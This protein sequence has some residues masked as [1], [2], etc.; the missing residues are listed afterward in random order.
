MI[1]LGVCVAS[2]ITDIDHIVEAERLGYSHAW[3]ADSHMIWSDP[4]AVLALAADRTSSIRLGTGVAVAG[5]RPAPVAAASIA[6][7]NAL[8]PGRT[9]FGVGTGNTA[10]RIMGHKPM[11][12]DEFDRYLESIRPLLRGDRVDFDW[13]GKIS[14]IRH[15]MPTSG[16]VA[17]EPKIPMYVSGF[18][19]RSLGLAGKH[20]DGAVL[21]IPPD[22][23][24]MERVW[25]SIEAGAAETGR[26]ID[27]STF[28]TSSLTTAVVLQPGEA[29]DSARVKEQC[30]AFA[31]A[32][33]HY[34][35]DQWR[36]FGRRPSGPVAA[37]WDEYVALLAEVPDDVRHLRIHAGHNCW[38]LPEE[39]RFLTRELIEATCL[40][41]T[42]DELARRLRD[43][44]AAG[45]DQI[46]LLPPLE[47]RNEVLRVVAQEVMP[48]L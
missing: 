23:V 43:L 13:R 41:G 38:V 17:F 24:F 2:R 29:P 46:M 47:P 40:V 30:G 35:Y 45:L 26:T 5:T 14:P 27:R 7:I 16:F 1:E 21:S 31:I 44:H 6:T 25:R 48:L 11:R 8:A 37:I 42:A 20:A 10:M 3:V 4:Y 32:S 33:L 9:F 12:I 34:S 36:Q 15:L 22:A 19:P 39:E 28:V 18:G